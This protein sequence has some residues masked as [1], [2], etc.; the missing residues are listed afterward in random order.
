MQKLLL[1]YNLIYKKFL[2]DK[3][4]N[5]FGLFVFIC[6][7]NSFASSSVAYDKQWL[8]L[9]RY[10][11]TFFG[12]TSE[13]DNPQYLF[14]SD[15]KENPESELEQTIVQFNQSISQYKDINKHPVCM[16]PGR[17]IY[18]KKKNALSLNFN[19]D[20]CSEYKNFKKKYNVILFQSSFHHFIS[21]SL[22]RLLVI[23]YSN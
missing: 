3:R 5:L 11:K 17:Y 15:G 23:L 13:V 6:I 9:L 1:Y 16:F 10:N 19:L 18:L 8:K 4:A 2:K 21:I 22:L 7:G 14:A 12:Y 20:L